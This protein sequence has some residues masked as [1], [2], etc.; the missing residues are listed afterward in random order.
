MSTKQ[1][2]IKTA[3]YREMHKTPGHIIYGFWIN[4]GKSGELTIRVEE[5]IAFISRMNRAGFKRTTL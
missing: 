4:G 1:I 2:D 3:S 5:E